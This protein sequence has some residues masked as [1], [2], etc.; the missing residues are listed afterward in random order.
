MG[1]GVVLDGLP[2]PSSHMRD[3][4]LMRY[5]YPGVDPAKVSVTVLSFA[6]FRIR[7]RP[8]TKPFVP[9]VSDKTV[10]GDDVNQ[11]AIHEAINR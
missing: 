8:L 6:T 11:V 3:K 2:P 5:V 7:Q 4:A 10:D 1:V 9:G